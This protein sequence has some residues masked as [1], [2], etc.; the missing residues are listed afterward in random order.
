MGDAPINS[1]KHAVAHSPSHPVSMARGKKQERRRALV[2]GCGMLLFAAVIA[3]VVITAQPLILG[4]LSRA[5]Q[6]ATAAPDSDLRTAKITRDLGGKE[7]WQ[8]I[9]DNRTGRMTR[10][11]HPCETTDYDS[12]GAPV[13]VGTIHRLDAISKSFSGH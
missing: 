1:D 13:P 8:D 10:S 7:C 6:V 3:A 2:I 9:F 11:S 5:P 4:H 12:N